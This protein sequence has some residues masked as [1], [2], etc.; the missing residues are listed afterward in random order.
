MWKML[1]LQGTPSDAGWQ[2]ADKLKLEPGHQLGKPEILFTKIEDEV[3]QKQIDKLG[4][5]TV[6]PVKLEPAPSN[7]K[8]QITIDDFKRVDL[9]IA[10]VITAERVPKSEKLLKLQIS[11]GTEQRQVIAGI[12]QHYTPEDLVGKKIVVVAN[13]APA[14]LMGQESQGML[15]AAS[16]SNNKLTILTIA[17]DIEEGSAVK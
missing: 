9:R 17:N 5:S 12:A 13:L 3:I 6:S 11:I 8:P 2:S 14:K 1:R 7:L 10:K 16:N 15:L 4:G